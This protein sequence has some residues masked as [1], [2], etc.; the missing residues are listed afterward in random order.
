MASED[1]E[2]YSVGMLTLLS[3]S[4][5]A[6]AAIGL[7]PASL[8]LAQDAPS[9]LPGIGAFIYQDESN[10]G[11]SFRVWSPNATQVH[12]M[13]SFNF[14]SPNSHPLF[15]EGN[16]YWSVKVPFALPGSQYRFRIDN[17]TQVFNRNDA[18][19]FAMTNSVG[20]S[21]VYD[22]DAYEWQATGYE[23]PPFN[24]LVI[25]E[26]H[27]GTF[28]VQ[29]GATGVGTINQARE[30]L[31]Y[32]DDLGVNAIELMPFFEFPGESSWGYNPA[33]C[34]A[35][36]SGYGS[37]DELKRF[38]DEAHER[39]IAVLV[40]LVY[41]HLGPTDLDLWQYDGD[42]QSGGGGIYFYDDDRAN[43]PWGD[44]RPD[45]SRDE[46]RSWVH[47]NVFHWLDN[48]R[49]D[50]VRMDGTKYIR[51]SDPPLGEL[52]EG[53]SLLQWLNDEVDSASPEKIMIA[54]DLDNNDWI[55][56]GT[57]A[58]G[59]GF[60]SQWDARFYWPVRACIEAPDDS[61]R[62]MWDIRD[63]IGATYNNSFTQ[64][65]IY[66]ESH[67]EV[68]N[69]K[70]RVPEE[71]WPG[72]ADSWFSKKR[73]TLG[74]GI[75][76]TAP[77]IPMLFQGQEFLEDGF[78]S[79]DD[80][81]DW[82]KAETFSGILEMYTRMISLR[83]NLTGVTAGLTGSNLNIHHVN[84][85]DKMIAYHRWDQGGIGDDVVV[86][87]NFANTTWNNYRI[88]FPN[89]G[90]W[91]VHFNSDDSAYDPEFDGY[92]GFDIQTQPIGWDG[93]AQSAIVNIAPYSVLVF[94][95]GEEDPAEPLTG[96]YDGNGAVDGLDLARLLAVWGTTSTLYDL[97]GDDVITAEDLTILLGNWT[98]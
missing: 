23:T 28:G 8:S 14:W 70:S 76:F 40:D 61:G 16:G 48:F 26:M 97:N 84:N 54:E 21:V 86:V 39:G 42:E 74:A 44:T 55:T 63:A 78:F 10:N 15:D 71:I 82:S 93:L 41:S 98:S 56:K 32:L 51:M 43:T 87:A 19:A 57:G 45:F 83:R 46:V 81:L 24:E 18:R 92:G 5:L 27:L 91:N 80:P 75:V 31:D 35:V 89:A 11:V 66:T 60:D 13:G 3:P 88:G 4:I 6:S 67:D 7:T 12:V 68:A 25:Y 95:Q 17:G 59:A 72:N 90:R 29:P 79:D 2:G 62:S 22:L 33:H 36:E 53:W 77:G 58:G 94:S 37:A 9:D 50:G 30:Y 20:N 64:R 69:G 47:D 96:D 85:N 65:V 52:P 38:V 73:S 49:F 1:S 34:Y